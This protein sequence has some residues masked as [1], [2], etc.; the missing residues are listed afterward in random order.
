MG[1]NA[2]EHGTHVHMHIH[3]CTCMNAPTALQMSPLHKKH[4][5]EEYP[6]CNFASV[7]VDLFQQRR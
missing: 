1:R 2:C 7:S 6:V 4:R 3:T 5:K